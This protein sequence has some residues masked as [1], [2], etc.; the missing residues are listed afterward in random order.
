[1]E[2]PRQAYTLTQ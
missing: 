1:M 2:V